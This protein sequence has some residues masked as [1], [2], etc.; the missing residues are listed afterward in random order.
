MEEL[1]VGDGG[2][3]VTAQGSDGFRLSGTILADDGEI[4]AQGSIVTLGFPDGA[5]VTEDGFAVAWTL[6]GGEVVRGL[7]IAPDIAEF[8]KE[9]AL[10]IGVEVDH[11][12]GA[13]QAAAAVMDD[14]LQA[15]GAADALGF[16]FAA[17]RSTIA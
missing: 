13:S 14:E 10:V 3:E 16:Q 12:Q 5:E 2:A 11:A 1:I 17:I 8:V 4:A 6:L 7:Q 15:V 9:T